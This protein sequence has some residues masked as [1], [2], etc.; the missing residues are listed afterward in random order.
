MKTL[1]EGRR[2][3]SAPR[4]RKTARISDSLRRQLDM[5]ALVASAAGVSVLALAG[6]SE[7][8]VVYTETHEVTRVGVSLFIDL[9]HDGIKDFQVRTTFYTGSSYYKVGLSASG[10]RNRGNVI[11]GQRFSRSGYFFS[12]ASALR[13]GALI[14]PKR[15]FALSQPFMAEELFQRHGGSSK[16]SDLG[17]WVG[18]GQ[19]VRNRYLGLKFL[20]NGE[21]HYGWARFSVTVQHYRQYG[22]VSGT[23]TGYAYETVPNRPIVAGETRGADVIRFRPDTLGELAR[24]MK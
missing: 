7:A 19:G 3:P 13:A 18:A 1:S 20:I 24:G 15:E 14:G 17:P 16:Y 12:A 8:E 23:L 4:S 2:M 9:N 5:Y 6:A 22:D 10:F 21:V 11:A